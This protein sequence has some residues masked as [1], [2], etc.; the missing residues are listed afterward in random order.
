MHGIMSTA[1]WKVWAIRRSSELIIY[2]I[3]LTVMWMIDDGMNNIGDLFKLLAILCLI[4]YILFLYLPISILFNIL[5]KNHQE[6]RYHSIIDT[7]IFLIHSYLSIAI[8]NNTL[9]FIDEVSD[10]FTIGIFPW[11]C[12][13]SWHLIR[14]ASRTAI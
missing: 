9:F 3:A 1:A 8:M 11:V 5:M 2:V 14:V 4:Y 7:S 10:I 6:S 12:V 13:C